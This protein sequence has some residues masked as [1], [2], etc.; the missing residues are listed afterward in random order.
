MQQVS[1]AT[2]T[3]SLSLVL[4]CVCVRSISCVSLSPVIA[5]MIIGVKP[6]IGIK[7]E[8]AVLPEA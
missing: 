6:T 1:W 4:V 7:A 5:V 8:V 3:L 2:Q